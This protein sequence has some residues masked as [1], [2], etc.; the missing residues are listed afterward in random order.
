MPAT[1]QVNDIILAR[2][3]FNTSGGQAFNV[4]HFRVQ[5]LNNAETGLPV[6]QPV[7]AD[8]ILPALAT[9]LGLDFAQ[10]WQQGASAGVE[11]PSFM[12][13]KVHPGLRSDPYIHV[14]DAPPIGVVA[15]G[16][17]PL[18]DSPTILKKTGNGER[19][20]TGRFFYVGVAEI[21]QDD[22]RLTAGQ[23]TAMAPMIEWL[24]ADHGTTANNVVIGLQPC[25]FSKNASGFRIN[26]VTRTLLSDDILK[27][28]RR[29]RPGKG[30]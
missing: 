30:I 10:A 16:Y 12:V 24:Q 17:I 23:I 5:Q 11:M 4:I 27:T 15:G 6:A 9:A 14:F 3:Q 29:R 1:I 18:Q 25:L 28:Q 13:Q 20:G 19:W 22:G 2:P 8:D 7:P 26:D 21:G